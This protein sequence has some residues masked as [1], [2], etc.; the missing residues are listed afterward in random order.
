MRRDVQAAPLLD[1]SRR[2]I[3]LVPAQRHACHRRE[4]APP[5][6]KRGIPFGGPRRLP[7]R[8]VD[9]QPVAV[10]HQHV[11]AVTSAWLLCPP[12]LR[13]SL[14]VGIG[15]RGMRGV[16]CASRRESS[17]SDCRDRP[18]AA[19]RRRP[20]VLKLFRLAQASSNVPSTVKCSSDSKCCALRLRPAPAGRTAPRTSAVQ[21]PVPILGEH[22]RV[23]DRVIHVQ[24]DKPA[25]QQVVVQLLHQHPL[26]ANRVQH[27][28]QQGPQQL[29]RRNRRPPDRRVHARE[30][31]ATTSPERASVIWR[32]ARSGWSAGTRCSGDT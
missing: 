22:R 13:A 32:M 25:E 16:A 28:Q 20:S 23:P 15:R 6:V 10:L 3:V 2:V 17:P 31:L 11:P 14:R 18:A 7:H 12:L 26:A 29:L 30:L 1:K 8:R 24:A 4:S 9:H 19:A 5:S 21:Q 27:L